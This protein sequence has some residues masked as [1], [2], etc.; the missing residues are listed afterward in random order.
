VLHAASVADA[1]TIQGQLRERVEF[2]PPAGFEPRIVAGADVAFDKRK[3]V[4]Y[5]A[6]VLIDLETLETVET[7]TAAEPIAFPYVPG[8]L[9]FRELP[10]LEAAWGRLGRQPELAVFDAHGY[11]HPRRMGLACHAGIAFDLPAIG[12]AKSVLYG[13]PGAVGEARGSTATLVDPA[14]G[15][16]IGRVLRTRT[17]VRPVY[18]SVGH[19][20]DLDTAV[21]LILQLAP[22]GRYRF[23]ETTRRSDR[24]A[25]EAKAAG[26]PVSG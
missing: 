12:C 25:A 21:D 1:R 24:L 13:V 22:E 9:S 10:A 15:V 23:P 16:E 3:G 14:D 19:Q 7:V 4:A 11:A 8:Y 5:A 2:R 6:V 17:R 18:V 20:I 26:V